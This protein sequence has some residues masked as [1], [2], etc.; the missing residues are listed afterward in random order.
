M[1]DA[2]TWP[3]STVDL[4]VDA[5]VSTVQM[6]FAPSGGQNRWRSNTSD[7]PRKADVARH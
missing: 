1:T 5:F 7:A 3:S 6:T 2:E 4:L